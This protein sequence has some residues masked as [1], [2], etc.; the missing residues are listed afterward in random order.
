MTLPT[1]SF[2]IVRLR[3][4]LCRVLDPVCVVTG[5]GGPEGGG[6]GGPLDMKWR[7]GGPKG[8]RGMY[9][10]GCRLIPGASGL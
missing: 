3:I 10:G 2:L 8:P 7:G 4:S 6:G 5:G 9:G 1:T